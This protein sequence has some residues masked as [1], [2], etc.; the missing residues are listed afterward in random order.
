MRL[1]QNI[2]IGI[3]S[4]LDSILLKDELAQY[5]IPNILKNNSKWGARD[6]R[7]VGQILYDI[8]RWKRLYEATIKT[9][10]TQ[11]EDLWMLLACW[12]VLKNFPLPDWDVFKG[13]NPTELVKNHRLAQKTR[14]VKQSIPDWLD[15]AGEKAFGEE[16]WEMELESLNK[17]A[18]LVLRVNRLKSDPK[19]LQPQITK[20]TNVQ[21]KI[22]K[23]YPDA[24]I[25][26]KQVNLKN[27]ALYKKGLFEVQDANSQMVATWV[28]PKP[29]MTVIDACAGAGGK[30]LH[31]AAIMKNKGKIIAL[32]VHEKKLE[33][34][35]KRAL[36]NGATIV[37]TSTIEEDTFFAT[38]RE[39]A[40]RVLIDAPC[41]GLGI[42]KR[43]PDIKWKMSPTKIE[44]ISQLQQKILQ[45]NAELVKIDGILTYAT[46][47]LFPNE[48][49]E[50]I[51]RFLS[52][53]LGKLFIRVQSKTFFSH[54]TGFDGFYIAN[55][56]RINVNKS[57]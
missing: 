10:T 39:K 49:E 34:L 46:C 15:Q 45:K 9:K 23:T 19:R 56:K 4:G 17:P 55:L 20:A 41:S 54:Q 16:L 14:A 48:N 36:R 47:T 11:E 24:L 35:E 1:H 8:I 37:E 13:I 32:D 53:D 2:A 50:Q 21:A 5:T 29:G 26:E 22:S 12:L 3:I 51:E 6:R 30:T 7:L 57:S 25:L 33:E 44:A 38:N 40:D 31:L 18:E 52:S 42:L 27:S 28:A 43:N